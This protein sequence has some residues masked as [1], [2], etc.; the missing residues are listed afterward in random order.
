MAEEGIMALGAR[1]TAQMNAGPMTPP[2][3]A[4]SYSEAYNT[5]KDAVRQY[6]PQLAD[7]YEVGMQD[8]LA[9][10][11]TL[12]AEELDAFR[13]LIDYIEQNK[14]SYQKVVAELVARDIVDEGDFPPVYDEEFMAILRAAVEEAYLRGAAVQVPPIQQFADGGIAAVAESMRKKGRFGD[15]ILAHINPEEARMLKAMGGSGT[16]NPQTGLPEFFLG[17]IFKAIGRAVRGIVR[18]VKKVL[19]SPIGRIIGTIALTPFVGPVAAGA[20]VGGITGGVKGAILGGIGGYVSGQ[21]FLDNALGSTFGKGLVSTLGE[22]GAKFAIQTATGTAMGLAGGAK[23]G[24]AIKGGVAGAALQFAMN[25]ASGTKAPIE[26]KST[27]MARAP[28]EDRSFSSALTQQAG[29]PAGQVA[30]G[31]GTPAAMPQTSTVLST[32]P[33]VQSGVVSAIDDM[34]S[35]L[36]LQNQINRAAAQPPLPVSSGA[37][38]TG[39][40][41][42]FRLPTDMAGQFGPSVPMPAGSTGAPPPPVSPPPP[43]F[44]FDRLTREPL[45]YAKDVYSN[46]ISPSRPGVTAQTGLIEKYGPL[47]AA[48]IG[49]MYVGGGFDQPKN[50]PGSVL[51]NYSSGDLIAQDPSRYYIQNLPNVLY[52]ERGAIIGARSEPLPINLQ[53]PTLVPYDQDSF[54]NPAAMPP[55]V[56]TP[57][58]MSPT[59]SPRGVVQQYNTANPYNQYGF[60]NAMPRF[61]EGGVAAAPAENSFMNQVSNFANGGIGSLN[62]YNKGGFPRR[63]GQ[64]SGPGTEKSDDIPAML[65]DGEFV[66]T[67]RA[68]RG[69][70]QGSRREGAKRM[71]KLMAML[72]KNAAKGA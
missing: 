60:Y 15:T 21:G 70:G 12:T 10:I 17:K 47:A 11:G 53:Q 5:T 46:Y 48:G 52:D 1:P 24:D 72:E 18:G 29:A 37:M 39:T 13:E 51:P 30:T 45:S 2:E 63:T 19:S 50:V 9:E 34:Y 23:L 58:S 61:A 20:I 14:D 42:G 3:Q 55:P 26:D 41:A 36:P 31:I 33:S 57:P 65:S 67:A 64:I 71:Y 62:L 54:G 56:Y 69:M 16:I 38:G 25:R 8:V 28:I 66:M 44:S 40:G 22:T 68:V 7:Q 49:A 4:I 43:D 32:S 6:H 59:G 35:P 27:M